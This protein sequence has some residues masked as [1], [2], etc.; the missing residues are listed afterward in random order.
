MKRFSVKVFVIVTLLHLAGTILLI[1][2]GFVE[3]RAMKFAME[4]GEPEE[5]FFWLTICGWIWQ[6]IEMFFGRCA[7]VHSTQYLLSLALAWS[8]IVGACCAML[9]PRLFRWKRQTI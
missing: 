6:P 7:G 4:T 9:V 5:S 1:D 2:A 3:L 8:V